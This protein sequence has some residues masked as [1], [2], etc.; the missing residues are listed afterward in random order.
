MTFHLDNHTTTNVKLEM[1][2][3]VQTW[4]GFPHD[5]Y[6][7][8]G[9]AHAHTNR[10]GNIFMKRQLVKSCI[11]KLDK[12]HMAP[13]VFRFKEFFGIKISNISLWFS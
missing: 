3:G 1:L 5:K 7:I 9:I 12:A 10:K 13:E 4:D 11:Y 2:L 8:C 6:N